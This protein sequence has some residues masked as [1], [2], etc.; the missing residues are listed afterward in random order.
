EGHTRVKLFGSGFNADK[1]DVHVRWGI[2]QTER[3]IKEQV[4]DYI[5]T[6]SDFLSNTM[7]SGSEVLVAYK[8]EAHDI[9]KVDFELFESQKLRTYVAVAPKLPNWNSTHG[10]PLYMGVGE[11]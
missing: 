10:G 1:E 8:R 11:H 7:V 5:Y 6:E 4:I 3:M 9:E 2:I